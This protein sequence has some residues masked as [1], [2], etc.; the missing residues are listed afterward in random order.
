[1]I[2]YKLTTCIDMG[3]KWIYRYVTHMYGVVN[4]YYIITILKI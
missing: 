2:K 4:Y 3:Y 1:M